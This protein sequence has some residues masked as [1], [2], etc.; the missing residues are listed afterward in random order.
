[1]EY[2]NREA[3]VALLKQHNQDPYLLR[4]AVTVEAVMR[5]L[6][7]QMGHGEEA[8]AWAAVGLLHDVDYGEFPEEHCQHAPDMLRGI[9]CDEEFI[10]AVVSHGY[11]I[12]A[13]VEPLSDLEKALFACDELTGLI[14]AATL[15]R[16]SKSA[17]DMELSS[18]KKKF[19]DKRFAAGCSRDIVRQGADRLGW[20]LEELLSR[21]LEAMKNQEDAIEAEVARLV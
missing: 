5:D 13:D 20:E 11:G 16:P 17:K 1:M 8:G 19:K 2:P 21:T 10:R 14:Y 12:C 6:A 15:M 3:A 4:H 7:M 18:L 9:G